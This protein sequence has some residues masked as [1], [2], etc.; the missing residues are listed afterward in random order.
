MR[1]HGAVM[2]TSMAFPGSGCDPEL[3]PFFAQKKELSPIEP[4]EPLPLFRRLFCCLSE[5]LPEKLSKYYSRFFC[6]STVRLCRSCVGF[7]GIFYFNSPSFHVGFFE[8]LFIFYLSFFAMIS[9]VPARTFFYAKAPFFIFIFCLFCAW[10]N[11]F[12]A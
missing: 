7:F 8:F 4:L 3:L 12:F 6:L 9:A 1:V 10:T 2:R 5:C 11:P